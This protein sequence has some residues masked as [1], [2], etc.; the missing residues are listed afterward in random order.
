MKRTT[1][2][3]PDDLHYLLRQ[4]AARR[5]TTMTGLVNEALKAHLG[6]GKKRRFFSAGA[7]RSGH[8]DISERIEEILRE[9]WA[10]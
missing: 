1:I 5:K 7:G 8:D 9:E 6:V 4:E 3:L 2:Q 10:R